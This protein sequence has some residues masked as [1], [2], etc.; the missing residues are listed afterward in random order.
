MATE[1]SP[2]RTE[3]LSTNGFHVGP[4]AKRIFINAK[5]SWMERKI[6]DKRIGGPRSTGSESFQDKMKSRNKVINFLIC[7]LNNFMFC[8]TT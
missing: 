3:F 5:I 8:N 2:N 4:V 7:S 1:Y 6:F